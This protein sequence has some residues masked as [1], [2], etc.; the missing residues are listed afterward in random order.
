LNGVTVPGQLAVVSTNTLLNIQESYVAYFTGN[1]TNNVGVPIGGAGVTVASAGGI[2]QTVNA[3][4]GGVIYR[5]Q[6]ASDVI[7]TDGAQSITIVANPDNANPLYET[8]MQTFSQAPGVRTNVDFLLANAG[9]V[10]GRVVGQD[11][12]SLAEIPI[13]ALDSGGVQIGD[14]VT[15]D[16]AGLYV[17]RNVPLGDFTVQ[18]VLGTRE[19]STPVNIQ[20]TMTTGGGTVNLSTF[21]IIGSMGTVIGRVLEGSN[22]ITS[23]VLIY[24][25]TYSL[26][27]TPNV[28][29]QNA[30][31]NTF[32]FVTAS[33][34][35]GSYELS[36]V[37]S[38]VTPYFVTGFY[39]RPSVTGVPSV[40]SR[41]ISGASVLVDQGDTWTR[42]ITW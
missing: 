14:L 1:I 32:L 35:D 9:R 27:G 2:P 21:T 11:N 6:L 24:A 23:G 31:P 40:S 26:T 41:T 3:G 38:S 17:I 29:S 13:M 5:V 15:T 39:N 25:S 8:D 19:R 18:P 4:S 22:P 12:S 30:N 36:V 33:R 28:A 10:T 37:G 20:G 34:P 16:P 42:D 7:N